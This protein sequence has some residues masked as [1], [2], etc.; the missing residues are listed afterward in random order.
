MR[1]FN[2]DG[3]SF[4]LENQYVHSGSQHI[5]LLSFFLKD[6]CKKVDHIWGYVEYLLAY[7]VGENID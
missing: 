3:K 1:F 7:S 5:H 4:G 2:V 6:V